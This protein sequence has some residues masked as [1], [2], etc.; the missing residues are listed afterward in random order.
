MQ[1]SNPTPRKIVIPSA[2]S[3]DRL[4][5]QPFEPTPPGAGEVQIIVDAAGINYADTIVR[6]GLYKSAKEYVGWPITPGFEVAGR[7]AALGAGVTGFEIGERVAAVTRF[8]GYTTHL[9]TDAGLVFRYPETLSAAQ[10]AALPAVM[11]TAWYALREL[12]HPRPG[13]TLLVHSA[14]G[15]VGGSL[16]QL[17]KI[18]GCRVVGVVGRTHKVQVARD[19]GA[20]EVIDKSTQDLWARAKALAPDGYEVVLDAN[21]VATLKE[22][23]E[24]LKRPGKLVVYGF[25]SMMP[26]GGRTNWFKLI[27]GVLRTPKFNPLQMTTNS[28]SVLAFNLSYLFDEAPLLIAAMNDVFGWLRDGQIKAP[29]V[30]TFALDDVGDAHRAIES[31]NTVGKLVLVP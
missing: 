5:V 6:R 8:G 14:A 16:V 28:H 3:Y 23:Y 12:A 29:P 31:G 22:S 4:T 9:N 30:Q 20:D 21:G 2:G 11:M 15:G 24:H 18:M 26:K 7:I 25:A 17:G 10:A 19:F 13:H 27:S 1:Q